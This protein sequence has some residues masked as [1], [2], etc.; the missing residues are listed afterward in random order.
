MSSKSEVKALRLQ[1]DSRPGSS[2][3][4]LALLP[5]LRSLSGRFPT[6]L[7]DLSRP[8]LA[9]ELTF[10]TAEIV[11]DARVFYAAPVILVAVLVRIPIALFAQLFLSVV[12]PVDSEDRLRVVLD[13]TL[14][15]GAR[16]GK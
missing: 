2:R 8:I 7:L 15:I 9:L 16:G 4:R 12:W 13:S 6:D 5:L 1:P 3:C 11:R 14:S 10:P